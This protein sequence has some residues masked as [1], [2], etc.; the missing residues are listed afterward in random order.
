MF[1]LVANGTAR[2]YRS[3]WGVGRVSLVGEELAFRAARASPWLWAGPL[4]VVA[5]FFGG[6]A[7]G[8]AT[9]R[10]A[11]FAVAMVGVFGWHPL[12]F[13]LYNRGLRPSASE[14]TLRYPTARLREVR[15][16]PRDG[17]VTV[18]FEQ[19][20]FARHR[21]RFRPLDL[22]PDSPLAKLLEPTAG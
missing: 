18:V 3:L 19:P 4:L 22:D 2:E 10:L 15:R 7:G 17:F 6:V 21:I 11:F 20:R 13:V 8:I 12:Y 14:R 9:G 5:L 1:P 16:E